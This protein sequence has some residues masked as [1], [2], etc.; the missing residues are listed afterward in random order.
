L[1]VYDSVLEAYV[2]SRPGR[3]RYF[4]HNRGGVSLVSDQTEMSFLQQQFIIM[5]ENE[6]GMDKSDLPASAR[7]S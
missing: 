4:L 7:R 5:A 1:D 2:K 6:Y 3:K